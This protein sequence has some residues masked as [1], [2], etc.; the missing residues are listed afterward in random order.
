MRLS[1]ELIRDNLQ[2]L[3]KIKDFR[4]DNSKIELQ[5]VSIYCTEDP[6]RTDRL[7]MIFTNDARNSFL[8]TDG[9]YII[10]SGF[11]PFITNL[12]DL[13]H[14]IVI[15]E[16]DQICRI[17]NDTANIFDRY[18]QWEQD[19]S[20][21]MIRADSMNDFKV[22][23][24]LAESVLQNPVS[25]TDRDYRI[26]GMSDMGPEQEFYKEAYEYGN[27]VPAD[28]IEYFR[29]NRQFQDLYHSSDI[30]ILE[31]DYFPFRG[32]TKNIIKNGEM[33]YRVVVSETNRPFRNSDFYLLEII[34]KYAVSL[35]EKLAINEDL[36]NENLARLF[37]KI[38]ENDE[39]DERVLEEELDFRE[40]NTQDT[41]LVIFIKPSDTDIAITVLRRIT[42][43]FSD[44]F[45]GTESFAED[46]RIVSVVNK[47]R[48]KKQ[49]DS[50]FNDMR[51]FIRDNNFRAGISNEFHDI[52][53]L[54]VYYQQALLAFRL[55][56]KKNPTE[57]IHKFSNCIMPYI[58][59]KVTEDFDPKE[60]VSPVYSRLYKYDEKYHTDYVKTLKSLFENNMNASQT[61][62]K[63]Y[64][65]R[66][67]IV[68]R[69]KR[70]CEIGQ[71]D[72]KN[73][74]DLLHLAIS[75][76]LDT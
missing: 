73:P 64:I 71:T 36:N 10:H 59:Y 65:H 30:Y 7:Y 29:N 52:R 62:Q 38:A 69:I 24:N 31:K 9:F 46:D 76:Y 66:A 56:K 74:E 27:Y 19:I 72:L 45:P 60:L 21:L 2:T 11:L 42:K 55:G 33:L 12:Q 8:P 28:I 48:L 50:C 54:H 3:Y 35:I 20:E 23:L 32:L 68:F 49:W 13:K 15:G 43:Q 16:T 67:T 63:L 75:F 53:K 18:N 6:F 34:S 5:G 57:W 47:T 1:F 41:Y 58:Y 61:A 44:S 25:V 22:L 40:W 39:Y 14:Y 70:I 51:L 26:I 4:D 37:R 17:F